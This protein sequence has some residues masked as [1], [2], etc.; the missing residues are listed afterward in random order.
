[1]LPIL[2]RFLTA[3]KIL[4]LALCFI[5]GSVF[6][7][8]PENT[9]VV[10]NEESFDSVSLANQY[11]HLRSIPACNVLYLSGIKTVKQFDDESTS[12]QLFDRQIR[13]PILE[14]LKERGIEK[15]ID[16]IAYSAGFPTRVNF[17]REMK[18]YLKQSG[19]KYSIQLHAPWASITSLTYFHENAYSG[20]PDFL[21]LDAND[22]AAVRPSKLMANP[23]KG[24]DATEFNAAMKSLQAVDYASA[25]KALLGLARKHPLQMS[26]IY[27]LARCFSFLSEKKKAITTLRHALSNG[28]AYRSIL[29]KDPAFRELRSDARFKAILSQM[30]DL[31]EG[32]SPTRSFSSRHFWAR[33]GWPNGTRSQGEKY[34]LS[35]VLAVTGKNQSTLQ[36]S[37]ARL[38]SSFKADGTKPKG[39]VYFADHKDPR[40]RTR[41][42]QFPFAVKELRSIGREAS[43]GSDKLPKKNTRVI[44][45]TLGSPV[46]DWKA[47]GS[48]F[49]PG[50]ICDNFTSYGGWWQ[51]TGQTQLSEF[52][53]AGAAGASGTVYE[54]FTI[55]PK[56]PTARWHAHY[57]RGSTL[58]ESYYQSVSGPFQTLLVGDPLCCP[59][60]NFPKFTVEGI[61]PGANLNQDFEL[62]VNLEDNSLGV[63]RYELYYDGVFLSKVTDPKKI[64]VAVDGM[65]DGYHEI[66]IVAVADT[67]VANRSTQRLDFVVDRS[68]QNVA[69]SA[70][71]TK[72]R[73]GQPLELKVESSS[74]E[75][76]EIRQ[77]SRVIATIGSGKSLSIPASR[78]GQGK[79]ELLAVVVRENGT[80]V[81]S[82]PLDIEILP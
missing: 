13:M 61:E 53:D 69:L 50:A 33:N 47:C 39:H 75:K 64:K 1:M 44:G 25:S 42:A 26:V 40:S 58:A 17:Q 8:G 45:A 6:A 56:I 73:L 77:N 65:N 80:L 28:F 19:K 23:F 22:Y 36:N 52:L 10:V 62:R 82:M 37:V 71:S 74:E 18:A 79:C 5:S 32:V 76:L 72:I 60:G 51:K 14:A 29:E 63:R 48:T 66:R 11:I 55:P 34:V 4:L 30:A 70:A 35:A 57:A 7:Q 46:L 49:L 9:L 68:G 21:E 81:R 38:E 20:S 59:Y 12:T 15:Q 16:C 2:S 3:A 31:P 43:I 54:P 67:P 24:S 41:K 27:Q 78:L